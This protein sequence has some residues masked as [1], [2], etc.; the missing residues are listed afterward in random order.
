MRSSPDSDLSATARGFSGATWRVVSALTVASTMLLIRPATSRAQAIVPGTGQRLTQVGDD[1]EDPK[2]NYVANEPKSSEEQD[3]QERLPSGRAANGRW[4]EGLKR[5][6]PDMVKRV[7]TPP[8]G[9]EGSEGSMMLRSLYTAVPGKFSGQTS[10][11]DF[12]CL[13]EQRL[14]GKISPARG[15]NVVCHVYIPP[16]DKWERREG[17]SFCFRLACLAW[18]DK[19]GGFLGMGTTRKLDEYWPGMLIAFHPGD[20][21]KTQDFASINLR[22]GPNGGDF[23]AV[24]I[25]E[26]G[27][28]TLGMSV[29]PDGQIHYYAHSGVAPLT[30][31][32]H[33]SS[34]FPYGYKAEQMI[35]FFFDVLNGD[36]G[37]WS[38]PWIIDDAFVYVQR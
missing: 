8:G 2:W 27:W 26:P 4:A 12:I 10:Q 18:M 22:A 32:D 25:K 21:K 6:Q 36:N 30:E 34:Q 37:Q 20:G 16:F 31:K 38:T 13:V 24:D 7:P 29:T 3:K 33:L 23:R 11:D 28:W 1:F 35:T 15:P 14:G 5:G 19:P 17:N 9:I